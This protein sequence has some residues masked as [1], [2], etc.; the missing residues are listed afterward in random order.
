LFEHDGHVRRY[1]GRIPPLGPLALADLG[2]TAW[3][4]ERMAR[5]LP[6]AA[7]WRARRA[8]RWDRETLGAWIRRN[9]R[10]R[11]GRALVEA[12]RR[13]SGRSG[14]D[15]VSLLH[16]LFYIRFAGG[17]EVLA[18]TSGG[19]QEERFV[20]GS[21]E[22][23]G[24]LSAAL[25]GRIE[26]GSEVTRLRWSPDGVNVVAGGTEHVAGRA[27]LAMSPTLWGQIRFEPTLPAERDQLPERMPQ[28]AAIKCQAI[29]DEPFWRRDRLRGQAI[30]TGGPISVTIDNSPPDGSPGVLL[31]F[32]CGRA[33]RKAGR[34]PAD[35]RRRAVIDAYT[36]LFG[37][38][39]AKPVEYLEQN[40]ATDP[41]SRGCYAAAMGPNGWT[42]LGPLLREPLGPLHWAGSETA[43]R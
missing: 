16:A 36:R 5:T 14:P 11:A 34:Q 31:G 21:S 32:I 15:E 27:V 19:A 25:E 3:R 38:A 26:L 40:W 12:A 8:G 1:G 9:A 4:L 20:G 28:G 29:Y 22:L 2:Q 17:L 23:A 18:E 10:T 43:T 42:E 24:R 30:S 41:Y 39:A 37:P 35:E 33:A 6:D 13:R 7:P